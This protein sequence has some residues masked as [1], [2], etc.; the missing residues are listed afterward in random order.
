MRLFSEATLL[1]M[2]TSC[3]RRPKRW[4]NSTPSFWDAW[5]LPTLSLKPN[6]AYT[7]R[8]YLR[9]VAMSAAFHTLIVFSSL[10]IGLVIST[11]IIPDLWSNLLDPKHHTYL[12][13]VFYQEGFYLVPFLPLFSWLIYFAVEWPR[14]FFWNRRAKRLQREG[15]FL[16]PI[17]AAALVP[18]D[19]NVWPPPP[20]L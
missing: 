5:R 9:V 1:K 19:P 20:R 10:G 16:V 11:F 8:S 6:E 4:E 15:P 7:R 3:T 14:Y 2:E 12:V 18:N 17:V 13:G